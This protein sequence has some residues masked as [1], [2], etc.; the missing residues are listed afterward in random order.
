MEEKYLPTKTA[1]NTKPIASTSS[2][3][4]NRTQRPVHRTHTRRCHM[5]TSSNQHVPTSDQ[6]INPDNN[7]LVSNRDRHVLKD[8]ANKLPHHLHTNYAAAHPV[9]QI[10]PIMH[11]G[12]TTNTLSMFHNGLQTIVPQDM[13]KV[14]HIPKQQDSSYKAP[15]MSSSIAR[16]TICSNRYHP[17]RK[18][19]QHPLRGY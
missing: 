13:Y 19:I 7:R 3:Y 17:W 12:L 5:T 9:H 15:E 8:T 14:N 10:L 4:R 2:L 11:S 16:N 1:T 6:H 18:C